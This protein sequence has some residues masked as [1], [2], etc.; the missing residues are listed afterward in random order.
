MNYVLKGNSKLPAFEVGGVRLPDTEM[1]A[2][3]KGLSVKV[4]TG[5]RYNN[6]TF[7]VSAEIITHG[8]KYGEITLGIDRAISNIR[9]SGN[10]LLGMWGLGCS[11]SGDYLLIQNSYGGFSIGGGIIHYDQNTLFGER[12]ITCLKQSFIYSNEVF[13]RSSYWY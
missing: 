7:P 1:Y 8:K 9:Y 2:T 13:V 3:S 4:N 5:Y 6:W 12:N 10:V 11:F